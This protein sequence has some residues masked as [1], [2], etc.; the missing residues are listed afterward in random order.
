VSITHHKPAEP[1]WL[2]TARANATK[3]LVLFANNP[4][5]ERVVEQFDSHYLSIK[6]PNKRLDYLSALAAKEWDFRKG[7]ERFEITEDFPIDRPDSK[8]GQ[9]V[10]E[11]AIQAEMASASIATLRHY[12]I[13][14]I[15]GGAAKSPYYRL[16]Y[17]LEQ[18]VSYDM[19]TYLGS[20]R[21]VLPP[22][23]ERAKDYAPN[24][25]TEFDLGEAAI[26]ALMPDQVTGELIYEER[27]PRSRVARL[28]SQDNVPVLLL[29]APP[30]QGGKR[31]N[32]A[33]AYDFLRGYE[34]SALGPTKNILFATGALYRYG[35]Y[36]DAVR[37]ISLKTGADIEVIG[38]EPSYSGMNFKPSQFLQE[39]KA[40]V[41]AA[42]RLRNAVDGTARSTADS[43]TK[44]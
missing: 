29:S 32:T 7:R 34:G 31:A 9:N 33:D 44:L 28:R 30:N 37:E 40:A 3:Y 21:E 16:K 8:A 41:D 39:L 1:E 5:V 4:G 42:V 19:L 23:H 2:A 26:R 15:L 22:E 20:E 24:A 27:T 36:F 11:G 12:S 35:Q 17:A 10:R 43:A 6:N 13:L 14:A 38:F 25:Q 18:H